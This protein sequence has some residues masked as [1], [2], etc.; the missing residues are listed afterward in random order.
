MNVISGLL[1]L[2]HNQKDW[3]PYVVHFKCRGSPYIV[4]F[5]QR[6]CPY[7]VHLKCR[8]CPYVYPLPKNCWIQ[9]KD[10]SIYLQDNLQTSYKQLQTHYKH[11][12]R[13]LPDTFKTKYLGPFLLGEPMW[14][15]FFLIPFFP[16][17]IF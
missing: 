5:K 6:D 1:F 15:F 13:H 10:N 4:H 11:I 14:R 2:P 7:V 9:N 3:G 12:L 8:D 17:F 16:S